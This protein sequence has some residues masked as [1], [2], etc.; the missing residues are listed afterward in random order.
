MQNKSRS[1]KIVVLPLLVV[2][3]GLCGQSALAG[4]SSSGQPS[5][6][7][8]AGTAMT[9]TAT[10][11]G[12]TSVIL[13]GSGP[14]STVTNT[15]VAGGGTQTTTTVTV[16]SASVSSVFNNLGVRYDPG[17]SYEGPSGSTYSFRTTQGPNN[18]NPTIVITARHPIKV[19]A[20][21]KFD[22]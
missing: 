15:P 17:A 10:M 16:P 6:S 1:L 20:G 13:T 22:N 21:F 3:S 14:T 12:L 9:P 4:G 11:S 7:T 18:I 2:A 8:I 19:G 5:G